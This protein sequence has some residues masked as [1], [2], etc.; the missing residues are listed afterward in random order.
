MKI[1]FLFKCKIFQTEKKRKLVQKFVAFWK[2]DQQNLSQRFMAILKPKRFSSYL[3][4][5]NQIS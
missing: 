3:Q 2:R 4:N 5:K 1:V